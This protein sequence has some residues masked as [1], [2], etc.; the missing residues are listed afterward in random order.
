VAKTGK[1]FNIAFASP[2]S[3]PLEA[4]A[5]AGVT[6]GIQEFPERNVN[7]FLDFPVGQETLLP[8]DPGYH[9]VKN[10]TKQDEVLRRHGAEKGHSERV[11]AHLLHAL[12][13]TGRQ[14]QGKTIGLL[15]SMVS[16]VGPEPPPSKRRQRGL[17]HLRK[18]EIHVRSDS[19]PRK[20]QIPRLPHLGRSLVE[21]G[22][23]L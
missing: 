15:S 13:Q 1:I 23:R 18:K 17:Q 6:L 22:A 10:A 4:K 14:K 7:D 11:Q 3:G 5:V 9:R 16:P 21:H 8:I 20:A 2:F 12:S 19:T